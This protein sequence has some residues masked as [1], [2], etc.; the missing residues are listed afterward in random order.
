MNTTAPTRR[1]LEHALARIH[2]MANAQ[3]T[4]SRDLTNEL[5]QEF[6]DIANLCEKPQLA[7][8]A[9]GFPITISPA[10]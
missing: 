2:R 5:R 10:A 9:F 6:T 3:L 7:A 1:Q 4:W 8:D